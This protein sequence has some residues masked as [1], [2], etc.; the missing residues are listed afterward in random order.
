MVISK[1]S[2]IYEISNKINGRKY[3]GHSINITLR[4]YLHIDNLFKNIHPNSKLQEDFNTYGLNNFN[5]S[6]LELLEGKKIL[7]EKEQEYLN[8]LD[9]NSN[10]NIFNSIKQN[11]EQN[12]ELF[13]NY[14]TSKWLVDDKDNIKQYRIY[15]EKDKQEI[16]DKA[17]EFNIFN[18]YKSKITFNR[19]MTFI[20]NDLDFKVFTK[21]VKSRDK[22]KQYTYKLISKGEYNL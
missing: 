2:G 18:L 20:S 8:T 5:F 3:I 11:K 6:I 10:Y 1:L 13:I 14:I 4:W 9:F 16:I 19:V 22:E 17:F 15:E 21:R 12:I 7:I